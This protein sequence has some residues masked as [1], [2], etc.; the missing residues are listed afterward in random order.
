MFLRSL[1]VVQ[2]NKKGVG[3]A[4]FLALSC[5]WSIYLIYIIIIIIIY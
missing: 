3:Q 4:M 1:A 5:E 2:R